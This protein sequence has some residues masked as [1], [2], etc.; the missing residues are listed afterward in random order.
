[1]EIVSFVHLC[2]EKYNKAKLTE[3]LKPFV[4]R[5]KIIETRYGRISTCNYNKNSYSSNEG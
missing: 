3:M 4:K 5:E 2:I 1:M